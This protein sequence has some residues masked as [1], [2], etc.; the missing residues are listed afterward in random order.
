VDDHASR[1]QITGDLID[2]IERR[3]GKRVIDNTVVIHPGPRAWKSVTLLKVPDPVTSELRVREFRARTW[4]AIPP[5]QGG[6]YGFEEAEHHWNCEG[7][8]VEIL[9]QFLNDSFPGPGKYR[10]IKKGDELGDLL[11]QVE[12]GEVAPEVIAKLIKLASREPQMVAALAAS[13]DGTLL[14]EAVELQRRRA[15]LGRLRRIVEDPDSQE[16]RNLHP[17]L[18]Q[19]AWIFG[20]RYIGDSRR[21]EL[22]TGDV[23]D[24]PLLRP[25]GSLHVVELKG[26]NI[27]KLVHRY[28]G[29]S[30]PQTVAG[31]REDL[32]L[33]VGA[34]V[35]EA[36]G[37]V[38]N[39]LCH[40]D[41]ERDHI[42]TRFKIEA[43]RATGTVLIGHPNFVA[44]FS[45]EDIANTLRIYNSH[46][47]RVEVM[48]YQD[49]IE[50]AQRALALAA[51]SPDDMENEDAEPGSQRY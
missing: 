22:A 21:N 42:L 32:P 41:E 26:A 29:P 4:R 44:D 2:F 48:H 40:L 1:D 20:G 27:P 23:L 16:R 6:K 25:D 50:N 36:V 39:Y 14:A 47:S 8:E 45:D 3:H 38:M 35:H 15:Q 9:R 19:M 12:H 34:E 18:K 17:Q 28:R 7:D 46:L 24:I 49:L 13:T 33:I 37:Q 30:N 10:L 5:E 51:N 43:R 31:Q 11:S